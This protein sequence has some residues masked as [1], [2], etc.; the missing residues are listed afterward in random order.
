VSIGETLAQARLRAGLSVEEVSEQTRIRALIIRGI[1]AGDY[2]VCGGDFYARGDIR[3]IARAVGTDPSPLIDEYDMDH[4]ATG[5]ISATSI[6]ELLARSAPPP[7]R[8]GPGWVVVA[9][10]AVVAAVGA[11]AWFLMTGTGGGSSTSATA[12]QHAGTGRSGS[13]RGG[14]A[15]NA[16]G[17][18]PVTGRASASPS[19]SAASSIP[20]SAS[21][22]TTPAAAA[23]PLAAVSASAF[24]MAGPGT[25]D[26]PQDAGLVIGGH[27]GAAWTTDWY[28]SADFGH[29]YP[30]TGLLL[31]MGHPVTVTSVRVVLGA[32]S[33]ASFQIRI[34]PAPA[35]ASL[36]PVASSSGPGGPVRLGLGQPA[37]GRYVLLWF[38]RL[39]PDPAGT[40]Q[41][42]VYRVAVH[43]QG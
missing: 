24:G 8:R 15:V 19:G 34:G 25:G 30:G 16:H 6:N 1:E 38:T 31:D 9:A 20:P 28:T 17:A 29:L 39:P 18:A 14:G 13:G 4:R 33:G 42:S 7:R 26:D 27:P 11:G 37:Q 3:S 35:L 36:H 23:Q 22:S 21:P 41:V 2:S 32:A 12:A 10:L 5:P 40:F 43:G